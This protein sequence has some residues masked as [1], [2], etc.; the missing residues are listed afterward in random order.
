MYVQ[1]TSCIYG[2]DMNKSLHHI[3][4]PIKLIPDRIN[5]DVCKNNFI[6]IVLAESFSSSFCIRICVVKCI[7]RAFVIINIRI[8]RK[9]ILIYTI[10]IAY[11]IFSKDSFNFVTRAKLLF[12]QR[13]HIYILSIRKSIIA[14]FFQSTAFLKLIPCFLKIPQLTENLQLGD[15]NVE[16]ATR[17]VLS[18]RVLFKIS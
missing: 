7:R 3:A 12:T 5:D 2:E 14:G 9:N 11:Q 15:D 6:H 18:K 16:P 13:W 8:R 1:F 4:Q 17:G 10:L